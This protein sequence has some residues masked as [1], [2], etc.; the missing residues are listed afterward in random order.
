MMASFDIESRLTNIL[1]QETIDLCVKNLFKD[2]TRV[3]NL[4]RLFP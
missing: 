3:D 2:R 4:S 1:L